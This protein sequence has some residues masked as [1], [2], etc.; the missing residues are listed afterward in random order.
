MN[1]IARLG[2]EIDSSQAPRAEVN[3]DNLGAAAQRVETSTGRVTR[4]AN[5]NAR[6]T[7][8]MGRASEG[9]AA[10]LQKMALG[11]A[12]GAAAAFSF[13]AVTQ[14]IAGFEQS[15]AQVAAITGATGQELTALRDIAKQLGA[16]TEFSASQAADGLRF[17]GMAGFN[18]AES[19]QAIPDVLNLAT[20][21]S[22]D[23]AQAADITSNI[24]G[25]FGIAA[26]NA[27]QAADVLA[28]A[29]SRANTD[30]AQLGSAMAMAGPVANALGVN[31]GE[32]AAAIG[33]LSD[34]GIQGSMAG[35]G[36]R[37]VL[38]SLANA[39]PAATKALAGMGLSLKD[40][41]PQTNDLVDIVDR[42]AEANISASN[43]FTIFGDRGAPAI[44]ALVENNAKLRELTEELGS[45]EGAAQR[46]AEIMRDNLQGDF[47]GLV[48]AT[49]AVIIALGESGLTAALRAVT[50]LATG[51]MR[52]LS[53]NME[54][55]LYYAGAA[56]AFLGGPYVYSIVAARMA[57]LSFGA[58]LTA[59]RAIL[60]RLGFGAIIVLAGELIYQFMQLVERAGGFGAAMRQMGAVGVDVFGRIQDGGRALAEAMNSV[61]NR[62][63]AAF[64][65]AWAIALAGFET[66]MARV[67]GIAPPEIGGSATVMGE[68][69]RSDLA[70]NNAWDRANQL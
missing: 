18:A 32:T 39:T 64:Q 66:L 59:L 52:I 65:R 5:E 21:A 26:S 42:L 28:L 49:E 68:A 12:A 47:L 1:D 55:V 30:V 3:L 13:R 50:Q 56:A 9:A 7:S 8:F 54:R 16:T 60:I 14:V 4:A 40:L 58:A 70:A 35:T 10:S 51:V 31:I 44:L 25:A 53:D 37:R 69:R 43:A 22:M 63:A 46:M 61:A 27:N 67:A 38:S 29:S 48:S 23:L 11:L 41:N 6:A 45:A 62:I 33:A 34:L 36:L 20:A 2:I 17:L 19:I 24:M 15:M 57:T